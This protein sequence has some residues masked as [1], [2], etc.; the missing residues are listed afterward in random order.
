MTP[1]EEFEKELA[2]EKLGIYYPHPDDL[3]SEILIPLQTEIKNFLQRNLQFFELDNLEF[4]C[5]NSDSI[6]GCA[7]C[8]TKTNFIGLSRGIFYFPYFIISAIF[9][10]NTFL[11]DLLGASNEQPITI[12]STQFLSMGNFLTENN[13][14]WNSVGIHPSNPI[15]KEIAKSVF[16]YFVFFVLMHEIGHLRQKNRKN[17]LEF[18]NQNSNDESNLKCQVYE[19]DADLYAV[20]KLA[21]RLMSIFD[22]REDTD[23]SVFFH[24]KET[25]CYF[26]IF[27]PLLL[28]YTL[29]HNNNF[30]KYT[31]ACNHPPPSL[32]IRY[33]MD[34]LVTIYIQNEFLDKATIDSVGKRVI[35]DFSKIMKIIFPVSDTLQYFNLIL[36]KEL[37]QHAII[38]ESVAKHMSDLNAYPLNH[39][40]H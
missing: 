4:H 19:S 1:I 36:D 3:G 35:S 27:I 6:N 40:L 22:E 21:I 31:L 23:K 13:I 8:C 20:N 37:H 32:R 25:V 18:D 12:R 9:K 11:F 39:N 33:S 7:T 17:I 29:S 15:R 28:F 34:V 16:E 26:S 14:D 10:E 30:E 5:I 38:L 24:S 2:R